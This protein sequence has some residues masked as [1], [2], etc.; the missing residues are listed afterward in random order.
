M[1][2]VGGLNTKPFFASSRAKI[3]LLAFSHTVQDPVPKTGEIPHT[4]TDSLQNLGFVVAALCVTVRPRKTN[5]IEN[6]S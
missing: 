2:I 5:R 6:L 4:K 3:R 1:S